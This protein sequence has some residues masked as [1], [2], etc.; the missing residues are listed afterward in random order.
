MKPMTMKLLVLWSVFYSMTLLS[1]L[2]I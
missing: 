1:A 2:V